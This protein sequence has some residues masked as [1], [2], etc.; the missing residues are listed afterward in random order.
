[1]QS[2]IQNGVHQEL[3]QVIYNDKV[4]LRG[5]KDPSTNLWTLPLNASVDMIHME[6]KVGKPHISPLAHGQS[7]IAVFT[8]SVQTR[9]NAVKFAHQSLCNPNISTLLKATR[10]G[11]LMGCPNINEELILKY[12]NP[13]LA[14]GKGH[15]KRPGHGI[16]STTLKTPTMGIAPIPDIPVL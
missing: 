9:A 5:K 14:T 11:F 15:M 6:G 8:H 7:H 12:L 4:I 10:C 3:F 16:Q 13:S 1:V 2:R